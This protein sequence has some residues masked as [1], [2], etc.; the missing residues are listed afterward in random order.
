[1]AASAHPAV[2]RRP[3]CDYR[4]L[5]VIC[6]I[7][8]ERLLRYDCR[9]LDLV[10][11]TLKLFPATTPLRDYSCFYKNSG[12]QRQNSGTPRCSFARRTVAD[13]QFPR[14]RYLGG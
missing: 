13:L 11:G 4:A 9:Q 3:N 2:R 14:E 8:N 5:S 12:K 10:T 6:L 1:M 7:D